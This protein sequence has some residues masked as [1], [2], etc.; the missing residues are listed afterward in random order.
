MQEE[1]A[2]LLPRTHTLRQV[3]MIE[4]WKSK[5][6]HIAVNYFQ[7]TYNTSISYAVLVIFFVARRNPSTASLHQ[8]V[9]RVERGQRSKFLLVKVKPYHINQQSKGCLLLTL[10]AVL[11]TKV[12]SIASFL[13]SLRQLS[14]FNLRAR[15]TRLGTGIDAYV[16]DESGNEIVG[17][18]KFDF[19]Y[20]VD[21]ERY[22]DII[23]N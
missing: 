3:E 15:P 17:P 20:Q 16:L 9:I 5:C 18:V 14:S 11:P 6:K 13:A 8:M 10:P 12:S 1:P 22:Y 23:C 2:L 4:Y 19:P 7:F 21:R